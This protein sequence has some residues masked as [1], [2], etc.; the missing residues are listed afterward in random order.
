MSSSPILLI[1]VVTISLLAVVA[2]MTFAVVHLTRE[3]SK[4]LSET[5]GMSVQQVLS[6]GEATQP[7]ETWQ[8]VTTVPWDDW[9]RPEGT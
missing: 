6:P 8:T 4:A 5:L 3:I 9:E 7:T 2:G 1:L